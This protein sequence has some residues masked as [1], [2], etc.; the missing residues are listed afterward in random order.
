ME[1]RRRLFLLLFAA[2]GAGILEV[3]AAKL[4]GFCQEG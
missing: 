1:G 2:L 3:E 4:E